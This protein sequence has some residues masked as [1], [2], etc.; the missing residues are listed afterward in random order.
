M[1]YRQQLL[2]GVRI[3]ESA[4]KV[5][6]H[7]DRLNQQYEERYQGELHQPQLSIANFRLPRFLEDLGIFCVG[8]P[9]S[10]K[11]QAISQLISQLKQ[12]PDFRIVCFDRNGEFTTS[13]WQADRDILFNPTDKRSVGWNHSNESASNETI[14]ASIIPL[15]DHQDKF[16]AISARNLLGEIYQR[17]QTNEEVWCVNHRMDIEQFK[18]LLSNSMFSKYFDSEKT[19]ASIIATTTAYTKF[20]EGL[21]DRASPID[22]TKWAEGENPRSLFLPLFEQTAE[23]YKPLYSMVF[24]LIIRGL[25]S[26]VDR[27][28][29]TAIIVDELGALQ[30]LGSLERLLSEG[31]KFKATPIIATQTTAQIDKVYGRYEGQIILQGTATKL[32]LNCRDRTSAINLAET[33]GYQEV[34]EEYGSQSSSYSDR[35]TVSSLRTRYAVMPTQ[36]QNLPA[37]SG[38]L[39]LGSDTPVVEARITPT[40]YPTIAP[41][42]TKFECSQ[43]HS[44]RS[45]IVEQKL[46][47]GRDVREA[48]LNTRIKSSRAQREALAPV[49]TPLDTLRI[50]DQS[51]LILE[52]AFSDFG[53]WVLDESQEQELLSIRCKR[54]VTRMSAYLI[55]M[56]EDDSVIALVQL[57]SVHRILESTVTTYPVVLDRISHHSCYPEIR[58]TLGSLTF[59]EESTC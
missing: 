22:F 23:L 24:E 27:K 8:S 25:L 14:A 29:K 52:A 12:R 18:L 38:F 53:A 40:D 34:L 11:T 19:L 1:F 7:L 50:Y 9:G 10:G 15:E 42:L 59:V 32:I 6:A 39:I 21:P 46:K 45:R 55:W 49:S 28:I 17:T 5:Q 4:N 31:R 44:V 33:I 58:E 48:T 43:D 57:A 16:W 54:Q 56:I 3:E 26:N 35:G 2:R 47:R 51:G 41:R 30:R 20:Y 36:I 13:F 37:L